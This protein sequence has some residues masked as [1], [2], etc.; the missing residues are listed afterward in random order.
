MAKAKT[1][2]ARLRILIGAATS[3]GPG[4]ADLLEA[5][6]RSGSIS[7]AAR[8]MGMSYRRAWLLVDSMN[9][10]FRQDLVVTATGGRGG[11]GS[12]VTPFGMD[13][14]VRYRRTEAT[15]SAAVADDVAAFAKLM[16]G[17]RRRG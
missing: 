15:A 9:R 7:A 8:A 3:L 10:S 6:V 4:K 17:P 1:N 13:I 16:A 5:I 14:L 2:G 11:G 12:R